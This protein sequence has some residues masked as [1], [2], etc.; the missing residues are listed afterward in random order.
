[1]IPSASAFKCDSNMI[2]QLTRVP[3]TALFRLSA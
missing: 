3:K 1:V 2:E